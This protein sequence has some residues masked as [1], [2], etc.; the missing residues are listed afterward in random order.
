MPSSRASL[1]LPQEL[2]GISVHKLLLYPPGKAGAAL[3][4]PPPERFAAGR[5][6]KQE[7]QNPGC[8]QKPSQTLKQSGQ[9]VVR[10]LQTL[11]LRISCLSGLLGGLAN[12]SQSRLKLEGLNWQG[13]SST[14]QDACEGSRQGNAP[15]KVSSREK[16]PE[17]PPGAE[18]F[19]LTDQK[20]NSKKDGI[21]SPG[22]RKEVKP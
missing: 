6:E 9:G 1:H 10:S 7:T 3:P 15:R 4:E 17:I 12:L 8:V 22:R 5:S 16:A 21:K 19:L 18:V 13:E 20:Q 14:E 2:Q 11:P